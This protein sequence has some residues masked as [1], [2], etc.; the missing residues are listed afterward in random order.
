V[1]FLSI[2]FL[3]TALIA[4]VAGAA[5]GALLLSAKAGIPTRVPTWIHAWHIEL[6]LLGWFGNLTLGVA[7][8]MFPKHATGAERGSLAPPALAYAAL[9]A[10]IILVALGDAAP[11]RVLELLAVVAFAFN[12]IPRNKPFGSGRETRDAGRVIH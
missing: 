7:Y 1:P 9:N 2:L 4:L 6:M 8:W 3:R 5:G 11:G 10:G 12:A